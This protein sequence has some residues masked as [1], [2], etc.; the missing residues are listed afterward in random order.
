MVE[1]LVL[2]IIILLFVALLF[3][4]VTCGPIGSLRAQAKS[5]VDQIAVAA[6][7][8]ETEYGHLPGEGRQTV[9][10][11]FLAAL[12][13]SNAS[14]NP[15]NLVFLEVPPVKRDKGGLRNRTFVDPWGGPYQI[16]FASGTNLSVKAGT[17][18]VE[19]G[20]RVGVWNDPKL[21]VKRS[22]W[23]RTKE[24]RRYVTSWN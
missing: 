11:D 13:G 22:W 19:V 17:N 8:F 15:R 10:G 20:K 16:A 18:E 5:D 23:T 14:I 2:L 4:A 7:A 6:M 9:C 21:G 24:E 3:P 12:M 1:F